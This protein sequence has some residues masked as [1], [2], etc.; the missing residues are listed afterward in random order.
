MQYTPPR[1]FCTA[2]LILIIAW[3]WK[4]TENPRLTAASAVLSVGIA[5]AT[6]PEQGLALFAGL[7]AWFLVLALP[8]KTGSFSAI[9]LAIFAVGAGII[10]AVCWHF[11]EF[12]MV[13]AFSGGAFSFPLLPSPANII[14]LAAY[15][16][17]ACMALTYFLARRVESCVLPLFF[18]GFALLPAAF[19]RCDLGHLM[20]AAP[21]FLLG[22]AAIESRPA[23]RKVWSPL[24][25]GVVVVPILAMSLIKTVY[26]N[27]PPDAANRDPAILS[28]APAP[29]PVIYR[30]LDVAPRAIHTSKQD[31][32]DTGYYY[33]YLGALTEH[34]IDV[35]LGDLERPPVRP[36]LLL[37][38]PLADQFRSI[39]MS[40]AVLHF[41]ELSPWVPRPRNPPFSYQRLIDAIT[42]DFTPAPEPTAGFRIWYPK[43][44][45]PSERTESM[46][47]T[48]RTVG[49]HFASEP[50]RQSV[51][52]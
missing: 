23:L 29:C 8:R 37:D 9:D 26:S 3:L 52:F 47:T 15:V 41:L 35:M 45:S 12:E 34:S 36:L 11:G 25:L 6:S 31:C 1:I 22:V 30:T 17:A 39:E 49:L 14:V 13:A 51:C 28:S 10:V 42:R 5:F 16:V 27:Q 44:W 7:F 32:L 4:R 18:S 33:L 46:A 43:S 38:K 50:G 20:I 2:F 21:A 24:A 40:V 48:R 19:G